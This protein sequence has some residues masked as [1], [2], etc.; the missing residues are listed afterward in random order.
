VSFDLIN[1]L[2]FTTLIPLDIDANEKCN[3]VQRDLIMLNGS[4]ASIS[5]YLHTSTFHISVL[6]ELGVKE[7]WTKLFVVG[8]LPYIAYPI[9]DGKNGH[10]FFRKKK[11]EDQ[12]RLI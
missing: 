9:G 12:S 6:G 10:I 7:S 2:S 4:I 5:W 8:P 3:Y 1:E 11:M